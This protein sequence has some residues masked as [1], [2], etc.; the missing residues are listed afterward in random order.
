MARRALVSRR[1]LLKGG[2]AVG[3]GLVVGFRLPF[4]DAIL[5]QTQGA[6]VF[7]PNQWLRIDRD[8]VVT[9]INSVPEMGQ[10][11]MTTMPMIVADELD[12]EW[13]RVRIESAPTDPK[14][15]G[16]PV[17][18]QQSYGGS[19]GVR[20]HLEPLRKAGAAARLMLRQAAAQEW[21]VPLDEVT[22]EP[23]AVVHVPSGRRLL[24]G[25][26]VDK[27]QTLPVPQNPPLKSK[28]QF[29]YI[30][31]DRPRVDVP[32]KVNGQAIYGIDVSLPSSL[33]AIA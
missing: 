8:G 7:A 13:D 26:L 19:R 6:G 12:A 3:S 15:Y 18:G 10:G 32:Q 31:K 16:N 22:T 29:R 24:Y 2:I 33:R 14:V 23:G 28:D 5:A 1:T 20:D 27:A 9:I 11:S 25:Q 21:G 4:L 17:T 30:G